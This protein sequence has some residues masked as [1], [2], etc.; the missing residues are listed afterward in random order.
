MAALTVDYVV[1]NNDGDSNTTK[2]SEE[3]LEAHDE[4]MFEDSEDLEVDL[5]R[6]DTNSLLCDTSIIGSNGYQITK[7]ISAQISSARVEL[8]TVAQ[9]KSNSDAWSSP[10]A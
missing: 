3:D 1:A 5:V 4:A 8:G 10:H 2:T 7:D 9:V 6:M